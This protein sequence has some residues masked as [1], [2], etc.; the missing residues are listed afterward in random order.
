MA[1]ENQYERNL[2]LE[3]IIKL[4]SMLNHETSFEEMLRLI[5]V[6]T[7]QLFACDFVTLS[8]LNP[9]TQN[10]V[11]TVLKDEK[12]FNSKFIHMVNIN[13]SGWVIDNKSSFLS[14]DLPN[15]E[16]FKKGLLENSGIKFAI[17][18]LL[19]TN[20]KPIGVLL[21]LRQNPNKLFTKDD[22]ESRRKLS[23]GNSTFY[24]Q[25]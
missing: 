16:R 18:V 25:T 13:I 11:K 17:G 22:L 10:T 14:N 6:K 7:L 1:D 3:S 19:T 20:D 8:I 24:L 23:F 4:S 2:K 15:D 5:S 9:E 12:E 21:I